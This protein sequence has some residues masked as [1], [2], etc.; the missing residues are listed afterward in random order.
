M[1]II[2]K[3]DIAK[4]RQISKSV[5]PIIIDQYIDDAQITDLLPLLGEGFYYSIVSNPEGFTDLLEGVDYTYD[6][7][8]IPMPGLKKVLS[9]FA[10]ARYILHGSA[11]DTPFGYV[12]KTYNESNPVPRPNRKEIYK[13]N[14]QTAMQYWIQVKSYLDRSINQYPNWKTC[15]SRSKRTFRL[16]KISR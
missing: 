9:L 4:H 1:R 7:V 5:S 15:N 11:T 16:N 10:Y 12:E 14:Q 6:G 2:T 13:A 3:N 8:T